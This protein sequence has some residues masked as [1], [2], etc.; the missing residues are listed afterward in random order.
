MMDR[1]I[2]EIDR[3]RERKYNSSTHLARY[4]THAARVSCVIECMRRDKR[5]AER[6]FMDFPKVFSCLKR[7]NIAMLAALA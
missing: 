3:S 2:R 6:F 7:S 5:K 1:I 4:S